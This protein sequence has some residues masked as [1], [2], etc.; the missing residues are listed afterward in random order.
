MST[1]GSTSAVVLRRSM[2]YKQNWKVLHNEYDDICILPFTQLLYGTIV[3][4]CSI[5]C[6]YMRGKWLQCKEYTVINCPAIA[7]KQSN[8]GQAKL[9]ILEAE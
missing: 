9:R 7:E 1:D 5:V 8:L 2:K 3:V 6:I 4:Y